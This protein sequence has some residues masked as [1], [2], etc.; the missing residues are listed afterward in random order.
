MESSRRSVPHGGL[1]LIA[2]ERERQV[3]AEGW[4]P[5]HDDQHRHGLL[6]LAAA[7]YATPPYYRRLRKSDDTDEMVPDTWPEWW[8]WKPSPE[9]RI[10]ELT[11]AGALIAAEIDRLQRAHPNESRRS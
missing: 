6:A 10:R 7:S 11:K 9:N 8:P 4:T 3:E 1:R 5:E 2:A